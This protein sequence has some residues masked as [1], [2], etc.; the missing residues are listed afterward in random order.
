[1]KRLI[2]GGIHFGY[3]SMYALLLSVMFLLTQAAAKDPDLSLAQG[4]RMWTRAMLPLAIL[5]GVIG[6]YGA[7]S[8][9]YPLFF[10]RKKIGKFIGGS[11]ALLPIAVLISLSALWLLIPQTLSSTYRAEEVI[12]MALLMMIMAAIN[13]VI[14]T[15]VRGFITAY[16]DIQLKEEL[17]RE[18][19]RLEQALVKAQIS[20]HFLFNTLNNIDV[21]IQRD[22][23]RASDYLMKLSEILRYMLYDAKE[24][25]RSLQS[26]IE[27]IEKYVELQRIRSSLANY[28]TLEKTGNTSAASVMPMIFLPFIENAFKYAEHKKEEAAIQIR[29]DVTDAEIHFSCSNTFSPN[30][31]DH[32]LREEGGLGNELIIKRLRLLYPQT[33]HLKMEEKEDRYYVSLK[34]PRT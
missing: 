11:I 18:S 27:H 32:T 33:H 31:V 12:S 1:M 26:E 16:T 7:Y 23:T 17:T 34:L 2:I 22:P 21:L 8:W 25:K 20:P 4:I 14:G 19:A 15:V 30:T 5:P 10:T 13:I 28:I 9:L 24:E 6:F 29:W 3:W